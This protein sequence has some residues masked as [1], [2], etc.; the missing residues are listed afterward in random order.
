M[1][2]PSQRAGFGYWITF[3]EDG[4]RR[5]AEY[6]RFGSAGVPS[7]SECTTGFQESRSTTCRTGR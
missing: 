3:T 4:T 6:E 1:A 5:V 7:D 2:E